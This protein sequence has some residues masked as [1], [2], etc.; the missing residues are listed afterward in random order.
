[1]KDL[2]KHKYFLG[3]EVSRGPEGIFLSQKSTVS[4]SLL[5]QETW[6]PNLL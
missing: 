6:A 3:I 1:M 2:G 4:T 5:I